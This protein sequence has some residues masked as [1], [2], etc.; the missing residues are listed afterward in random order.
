MV[1]A[2]IKPDTMPDSPVL[3]LAF[4]FLYRRMRFV[5]AA[6][7]LFRTSVLIHRLTDFH[8]NAVSALHGIFVLLAEDSDEKRKRILLNL[9]ALTLRA[10]L[11]IGAVGKVSS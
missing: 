11:T 5:S 9:C 3:Y 4:L 10:L 2:I 1:V 7:L 6:G 8:V